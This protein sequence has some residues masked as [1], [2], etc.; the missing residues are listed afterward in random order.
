[1]HHYNT[2]LLSIQSE[3]QNNQQ[4]SQNKIT[5]QNQT[6]NKQTT[7]KTTKHVTHSNPNQ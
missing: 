2:T 6:D 4:Q 1:M 5:K 3:V 7:I